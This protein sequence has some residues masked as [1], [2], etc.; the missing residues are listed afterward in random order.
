MKEYDDLGEPLNESTQEVWYLPLNLQRIKID[1]IDVLPQSSCY[2]GSKFIDFIESGVNPSRFLYSDKCLK[3]IQESDVYII[4][5]IMNRDM[6][7][8]YT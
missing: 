5:I 2:Y 1:Y 4:I 7:T 8:N 3:L 6:L